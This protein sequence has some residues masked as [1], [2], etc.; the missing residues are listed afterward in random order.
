ML[1]IRRRA[2]LFA[3]SHKPR[4]CRPGKRGPNMVPILSSRECND[5]CQ[6]IVTG[7]DEDQRRSSIS[8]TWTI[9]ANTAELSLAYPPVETSNRLTRVNRI[10]GRLNRFGRSFAG[11]TGEFT[12]GPACDPDPL[13]WP[14]WRPPSGRSCEDCPPVDRDWFIPEKPAFPPIDCW[15]ALP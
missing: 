6:T 4:T 1:R 15:P 5:E 3:S 7:A 11:N 2:R 13:A 14:A 12:C 8:N 10:S 9:V